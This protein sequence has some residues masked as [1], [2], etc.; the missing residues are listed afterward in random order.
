MSHTHNLGVYACM[1]AVVA[2]QAN[3]YFLYA[4]FQTLLQEGLSTHK[5]NAIGMH[6]NGLEQANC[7]RAFPGQAHT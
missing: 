6:G 7:F 2:R 5:C 4:A 1:Y 3:V